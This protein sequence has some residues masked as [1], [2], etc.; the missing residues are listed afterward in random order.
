[1][2]KPRSLSRA[3]EL[4]AYAVYSVNRQK[5]GIV[6]QLAR[7]HHTSWVGMKGILDRVERE[8]KDSRESLNREDAA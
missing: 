6:A 5:R 4:G 2:P 7:Q 1:M 3:D 8:F